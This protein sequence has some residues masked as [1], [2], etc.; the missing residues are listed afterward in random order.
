MG[1]I[2]GSNS[3]LSTVQVTDGK[4]Q[5]QFPQKR[6]LFTCAREANA[7]IG[8]QRNIRI[9]MHPIASRTSP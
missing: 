6:C 3:I 5:D 1:I 8:V 9:D 2:A 7:T 4:M